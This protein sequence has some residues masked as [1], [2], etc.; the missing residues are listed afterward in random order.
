M[1]VTNTKQQEA[2][3]ETKQVLST[4][5]IGSCYLKVVISIIDWNTNVV[6]INNDIRIVENMFRNIITHQLYK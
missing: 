2:K 5:N 3:K 6:E 4:L 1:F